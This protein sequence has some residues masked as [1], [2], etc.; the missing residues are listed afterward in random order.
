MI[1]EH[2]QPSVEIYRVLYTVLSGNKRFLPHIREDSRANFVLAETYI[3]AHL[4]RKITNKEL[5]DVCGISLQHFL[6][7]FKESYGV[8]PQ[9]F[10]M[11]Q[12]LSRAQYALLHTD[13]SVLDISEA[14]GFC[15]ASHLI[16]RFTEKYGMSPVQYKK[17][18]ASES[19][20]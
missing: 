13:R 9:E 8:T 12:R 2:Y 4:P 15:D 19:T 7:L 1:D 5:A 18:H 20:E 16:R 14:L 3:N 6:K 11:Q 10:I 17:M